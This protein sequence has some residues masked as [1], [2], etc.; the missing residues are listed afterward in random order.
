MHCLLTVP[1]CALAAQI[2]KSLSQ[3]GKTA[4]GLRPAYLRLDISGTDMRTTEEISNYRDLQTLVLPGNDLADLSHLS[5]LQ[6]LTH[7]DVSGN[8]LAQVRSGRGWRVGLLAWSAMRNS[9]C[10]HCSSTMS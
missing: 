5:R 4:D 8:K 3:L 9:W 1:A 10:T 7:L 6:S 2:P